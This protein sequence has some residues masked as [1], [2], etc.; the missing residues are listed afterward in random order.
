VERLA[1]SGREFEDWDARLLVVLPEA[2][3]LPVAFATVVSDTGGVLAETGSAAVIVADR[4]GQVFHAYGAGTG[5]Q[6][7]PPREIE[8]WLKYLGTLCPE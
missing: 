3:R 7:P 6:F 5:H 2:G 8:E 1:A 4:Y